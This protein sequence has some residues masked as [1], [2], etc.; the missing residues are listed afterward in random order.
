MYLIEILVVQY[1]TF[2]HEH[3]MSHADILADSETAHRFHNSYRQY[4]RSPTMNTADTQE[5]INEHCH[6]PDQLPRFLLSYSQ[7]PKVEPLNVV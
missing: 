4:V 7:L 6:A 1:H 3:T 2:L 5:L